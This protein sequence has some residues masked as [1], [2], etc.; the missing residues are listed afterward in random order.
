LKSYVHRSP[1]NSHCEQFKRYIQSVCIMKCDYCDDDDDSALLQ[2][3]TT[4]A[5]RNK[6]EDKINFN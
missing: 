3:T 2:F 6:L 5:R 4:M 1:L